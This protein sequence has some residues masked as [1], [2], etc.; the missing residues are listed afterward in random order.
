MATTLRWPCRSWEPPHEPPKFIQ[1]KLNLRRQLRRGRRWWRRAAVP[2]SQE[3]EEGLLKRPRVQRTRQSPKGAWW[4][5]CRY[6]PAAAT[7]LPESSSLMTALGCRETLRNTMAPPPMW[8]VD[9]V[10]FK[11][12]I[13]KL[14][15]SKQSCRLG[16]REGNELNIL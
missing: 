1:Q 12:I 6:A 10:K 16:G 2:A 3:C 9:E 14:S 5:Y 11:H 15:W 8:T 7:C 4:S 13:L